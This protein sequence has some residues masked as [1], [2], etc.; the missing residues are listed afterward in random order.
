MLDL[1][2]SNKTNIKTCE[3]IADDFAHK[4]RPNSS[5]HLPQRIRQLYRQYLILQCMEQ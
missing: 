2:E 4:S 1:L 5:H 3:S